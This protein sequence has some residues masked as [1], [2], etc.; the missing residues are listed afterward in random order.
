MIK[1]NAV[2]G[3]GIF[4]FKGFFS[5]FRKAPGKFFCSL[6]H[7]LK[8]AAAVSAEQHFIYLVSRNLNYVV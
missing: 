7:R 6:W 2:V 8:E 4:K 5:V 3:L 1:S